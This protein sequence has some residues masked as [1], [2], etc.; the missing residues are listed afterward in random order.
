VS[1]DSSTEP[2]QQSV[3]QEET[4]AEPPPKPLTTTPG[5][6]RAAAA[7]AGAG[8]PSLLVPDEPS[9]DQDCR[10]SNEN[11]NSGTLIRIFPESSRWN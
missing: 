2:P 6:R 10:T 1:V 9:L 3:E 11:E 7:G 5:A 4:Y 8:F